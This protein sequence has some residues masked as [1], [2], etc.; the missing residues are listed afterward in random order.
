MGQL[1]RAW[2]AL[3]G[4][5]AWRF[6]AAPLLRAFPRPAQG[7]ALATLAPSPATTPPELPRP[8]VPPGPHT[9]AQAAGCQ[10]RARAG[11]RV[12]RP[13]GASCLTPCGLQNIRS[14][15]DS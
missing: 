2:I 11:C 1:R 3:T 6:R 12:W 5:V 7:S 14:T 10:P 13:G 4:S 15:A 8:Y 9:G